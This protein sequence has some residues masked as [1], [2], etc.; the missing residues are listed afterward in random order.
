VTDLIRAVQQKTD[1]V[2][3][4]VVT[5]SFQLEGDLHCPKVGKGK[6]LLTNLL[7]APERRFVVLT[8]VS[9]INRDTGRADPEICPMLQVNIEAIEIIRPDFSH[10]EELE[11]EE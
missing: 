10:Q 11:D 6:R 8:N 3:A 2:R 4:T 7:N 1:V 5:R 9:V